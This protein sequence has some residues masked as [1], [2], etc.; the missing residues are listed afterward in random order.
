MRCYDP[1]AEEKSPR[2]WRV[3]PR[4]IHPLAPSRI[5]VSQILPRRGRTGCI[6]TRERQWHHRTD[7]LKASRQLTM[8]LRLNYTSD[9]Q[10]R[11]GHRNTQWQLTTI[12]YLDYA[13][14]AIVCPFRPPKIPLIPLRLSDY[15]SSRPIYSMFP[16]P[17]CMRLHYTLLPRRRR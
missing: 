1:T 13:A 16:P 7:Y 5:L 17:P 6:T 3:V 14:F 12:V 11:I 4:I 10:Y 2:R 15:D 9:W 8:I